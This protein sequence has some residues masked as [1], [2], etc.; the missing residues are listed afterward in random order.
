M[1]AEGPLCPRRG[2]CDAGHPSLACPLPSTPLLFSFLSVTWTW[3]FGS[4]RAVGN[5]PE[6]SGLP[7]PC[8]GGEGQMFPLVLWVP[9]PARQPL[10][11][12]AERGQPAGSRRGWGLPGGFRARWAPCVGQLL[13]VLPW[14]CPPAEKPAVNSP[15]PVKQSSQEGGNSSEGGNEF[16]VLSG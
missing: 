4:F 1:H 11:P 2:A 16:Q 15:C 8:F 10:G 6:G 3:K 5:V 14:L 9:D 7:L 12:A 13:L